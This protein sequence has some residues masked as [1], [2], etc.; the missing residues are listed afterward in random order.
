MWENDDD[1]EEEEGRER[2]KRA[3]RE[4]LL[5]LSLLPFLSLFAHPGAVRLR[6]FSDVSEQKIGL[7]RR[8]ER[9][10][11]W[12]KRVCGLDAKITRE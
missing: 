9:R 5:L 10:A 4:A 11:S 7:L 12:L 2:R 8:L 3:R 1:D 6:V